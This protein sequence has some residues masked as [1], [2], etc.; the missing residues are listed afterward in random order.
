MLLIILWP[1]P[2]MLWLKPTNPPSKSTPTHKPHSRHSVFSHEGVQGL[3]SKHLQSATDARHYL[4]WVTFLSK[5]CRWSDNTLTRFSLQSRLNKWPWVWAWHGRLSF[6]LLAGVNYFVQQPV[7][8]LKRWFGW[9]SIINL[10]SYF[11][12][13]ERSLSTEE[14]VLKIRTH[15]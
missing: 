5:T 11:R 8:G 7:F 3:Q 1:K 14:K 9:M 13:I 15:H 4:E 6:L 2:L 10:V 12:G